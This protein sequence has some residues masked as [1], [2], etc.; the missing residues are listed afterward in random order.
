MTTPN[1]EQAGVVSAD[2]A[3]SQPQSQQ[4]DILPM[5]TTEQLEDRAPEQQRSPA[6]NADDAD[7]S[8]EF[9]MEEEESDEDSDAE[10]TEFAGKPLLFEEN[11]P[12]LLTLDQCKVLLHWLKKQKVCVCVWVGGC[13][14]SHDVLLRMC[15]SSAFSLSLSLSFSLL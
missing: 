5:D 1:D 14:S 15:S 13:S 2:P 3:Q 11:S 12:R 9:S 6:P 10:P 8:V 7:P 4:S